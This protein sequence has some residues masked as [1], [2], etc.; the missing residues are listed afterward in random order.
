MGNTFT[1][2][3]QV[4][5]TAIG[6]LFPQHTAVQAF[7]IHIASPVSLN[8]GAIAGTTPLTGGTQGS[9]YNQTISAVGGLAPVTIALISGSVPAGLNFNNGA[10]TGTPTGTGLSTFTVRATDSSHPAQTFTSTYTINIVSGAANAGSITWV[11]QPANSTGGQLLGGSPL[12]VQVF[13]NTHAVLPGVHVV[14]SFSG[15]APCSAA[16][17]SGTLTQTTDATGTATFNDLSIDRGQL[18][19]RVLA[20][21]ATTTISASS[22]SFQVSGFCAAGNMNA[23]RSNHVAVKLPNGAVLLAGGNNAAG[24]SL[25]STESRA[26]DGAFVLNN[27]MQVPRS[28]FTGTLLGSGVTAKVLLAGG[29]NNGSGSPTVEIFDPGTGDFVLDTNH[30]TVGRY[31]HT[32]TLLPNGDVLIAG[33]SSSFGSDNNNAEIYHAANGTFSPLIPMTSTH[34]G[35]TATLLPNGKV[36][37]AGG[38]TLV[39]SGPGFV[40]TA[41]NVAELFDPT[42]NTFTATGPMHTARSSHIAVLLPNGKV[43]VAG[44]TNASNMDE[45]SAELYDPSAGTFTTTGSMTPRA[46]AAAA[47][48]PNGK[49]LVIGGGAPQLNVAQLYD[50][51]AGTFSTILPMLSARADFPAV[52]LNDGTVLATGGFNAP[53]VIT[54]AEIYYPVPQTSFQI[55]TPSPL[56]GIISQPFTEVMQQQGGVG[57]LT[58]STDVPPPGFSLTSDGILSGTSAT[59]NSF[60]IPVLVNDSS[61]AASKSIALNIVNPVSIT[62]TTATLANAVTQQGSL[63]TPGPAPYSFQLQTA[64]GAGGANTFSIVGGALPP[65]ITL[66]PSGLLSSAGSVQDPRNSTFNF[67]VKAV[68]AGPPSSSGTQALTLTVVPRLD[69]STSNFLPNGTVGVPYSQDLTTTGGVPPVAYAY[70]SG[71]IPPGLS[72]SQVNTTT[73]RISGTPTA[74]GTYTFTFSTA[75]STNPPQGFVE[76]VT[77]VIG[78]AGPG[79]VASMTFTTEPARSIAGQPFS[80]SPGVQA[81]DA[82]NNPVPNAMITFS[83]A[84]NPCTTATENLVPPS[85]AALTDANGIATFGG[86]SLGPAGKPGFTL[87]AT[88]PSAVTTTSASFLNVGSCP[89]ANSPHATR[90][91]AT[92]TLLQDGTILITGGEDSGGPVNTAEIYNPADGTFTPTTAFTGGTNMNIARSQHTATLLNN[93]DVIITAGASGVGTPTPVTNRLEI[94]SPSS[95]SFSFVSPE[96]ATARTGHTATLLPDGASVLIAGGYDG[97]SPVGTAQIYQ[98]GTLGPVINMVTPRN[99]PS[100]ILLPNGNVLITGGFTPGHLNGTGDNTAE[101]YNVSAGTF[102][103]HATDEQRS[104]WAHD[105]RDESYGRYCSDC[106]R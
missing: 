1:F 101:L 63:S 19:Y 75:D 95:H 76:G 60:V 55:T 85:P 62:T 47:V 84:N 12:K 77:I 72:V 27:D 44:G 41:I 53:N 80:T 66:S 25:A 24:T 93:G 46:N 10:I 102:H 16:A 79:P 51:A 33:G 105:D 32:A 73:G 21:V 39:P 14:M 59:T 68:S 23:V 90:S 20:T 88:A 96:L 89:T 22:N 49:V 56:I 94:Y 29:I 52:L 2:S 87:L 3:V 92:S 40:E 4:K 50:P 69:T 54:N 34:T 104:C 100:A 26:P 82:G 57:N 71:P 17:L 13:D 58:W 91:G 9:P 36:L 18:G 78:S 106:R 81:L 30:M 31:Q 83:I 45:G 43:L 61:S 5:D 70:S 99:Q 74:P 48:L 103:G 15:T 37:I 67:T 8:P 7:T 98:N 65:D 28:S 97:T 35:G 6:T 64:G 38:L 86:L 42:T 11:N